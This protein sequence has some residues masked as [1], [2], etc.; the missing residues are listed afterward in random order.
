MSTLVETETTLGGTAG[1]R[2]LFYSTL[3]VLLFLFSFKYEILFIS[4]GFCLLSI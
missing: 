4:F 2:R 3:S 1:T